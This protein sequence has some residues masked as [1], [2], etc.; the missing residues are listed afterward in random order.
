MESAGGQRLQQR[1]RAAQ[2]PDENSAAAANQRPAGLHWK[3]AGRDAPT[4]SDT[5]ICLSTA[6]V[7]TCK[8][9]STGFL[10]IPADQKCEMF[11][12]SL[13]NRT[14]EVHRLHLSKDEQTVYDVVFAQSR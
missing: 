8:S 12:V 9:V 11:Q 14:C 1:Q 2:H 7:F 3:T 4:H 6:L 10:Y 13:P 5:H